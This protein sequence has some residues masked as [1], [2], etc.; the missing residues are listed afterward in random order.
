M[1]GNK[2]DIVAEAQQV[3]N[4][5]KDLANKNLISSMANE[6]VSLRAEIERLNVTFNFP[7][8]VRESVQHLYDRVF[9]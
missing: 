1:F 4:S 8:D 3:M 6:I 2:R 9:P 7:S 5:N